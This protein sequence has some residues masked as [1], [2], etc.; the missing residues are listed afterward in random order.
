MTRYLHNV[1]SME[2][3]KLLFL[4]QGLTALESTIFL[5]WR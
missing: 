4:Y 3:E 5:A 1:S 2:F